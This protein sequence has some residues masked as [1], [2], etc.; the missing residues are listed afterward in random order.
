M[1]EFTTMLADNP[2]RYTSSPSQS[3][4]PAASF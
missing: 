3:D 4:P 2:H 1:N